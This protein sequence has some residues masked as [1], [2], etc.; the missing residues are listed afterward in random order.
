[1]SLGGQFIRT[2]ADG[3]RLDSFVFSGLGELIS[4]LLIT[5]GRTIRYATSHGVSK[6]RRN[7]LAIQ[8]ALRNVVDRPEDADLWKAREYWDMY[9]MG[10]K[11]SV[12]G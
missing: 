11:V 2:S 1:V 4:Q 6:I 7:M 9:E 8:Q 3:C 12:G 10:P 5:Y